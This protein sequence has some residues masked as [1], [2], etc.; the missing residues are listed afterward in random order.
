MGK[1]RLAQRAA[2]GIVKEDRLKLATLG[3]C[4]NI[5]LARP[6]TCAQRVEVAILGHRCATHFVSQRPVAL[7]GRTAVYA[8]ARIV[9]QQV[10]AHHR[11]AAPVDQHL[12]R[13]P[14]GIVDD[15]IDAP[16]RDVRAVGRVAV[17]RIRGEEDMGGVVG[18]NIEKGDGGVGV[19]ELTHQDG[20]CPVAI[21]GV[22]A[23]RAGRPVPDRLLTQ[24]EDHA[25]VA[26]PGD[27]VQAQRVFA[28]GKL[29]G[30]SH[31]RAPIDDRDNV[32]ERRFLDCC[33]EVSIR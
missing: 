18:Q 11:I 4:G 12:D 29:G 24:R 7:T 9:E 31:A 30:A 27:P 33:D 1:D 2:R 5:D 28:A 10:D 25:I 15:L 32:P 23:R 6:R 8:P 20:G 3:A 26:L 21:G 19:V 13:V 14:V 17:L 16:A 22:H